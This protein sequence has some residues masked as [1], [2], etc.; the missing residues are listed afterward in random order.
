MGS[1][2]HSPKSPKS[3]KSA[4]PKSPTSPVE[5]DKNCDDCETEV[6]VNYAP[7][8]KNVQGFYNVGTDIET[9]I[10]FNAHNERKTHKPDG[11]GLM[12]EKIREHL[13][14]GDFDD[15]GEHFNIDHF[16]V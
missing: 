13:N 15:F 6:N 10:N 11:I 1:P 7:I 9:N 3:P 16:R 5:C 12:M 8:N 14:N 2:K 4:S